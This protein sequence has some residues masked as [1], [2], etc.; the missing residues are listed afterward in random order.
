MQGSAVISDA[1]V[2]ASVL[3]RDWDARQAVLQCCRLL[4]RS[5]MVNK[6]VLP[7]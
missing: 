4:C 1:S 3:E 2:N 5:V 6:Y 7:H